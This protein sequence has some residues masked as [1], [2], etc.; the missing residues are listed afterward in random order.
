MN[1][2]YPHTKGQAYTD[3]ITTSTHLMF[4]FGW[5]DAVHMWISNFVMSIDIEIETIEGDDI[6][7]TYYQSTLASLI[8]LLR[9]DNRCCISSCEGP[10]ANRFSTIHLGASSSYSTRSCVGID[11]KSPQRAMSGLLKLNSR[12]EEIAF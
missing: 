6:V 8:S 11:L 1:S 10:P 7:D 5:D 12:V 2:F 4:I 9:S 3:H